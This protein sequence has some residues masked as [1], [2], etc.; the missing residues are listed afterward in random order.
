[1]FI[2]VRH[3]RRKRR[4]YRL[5]L[6]IRCNKKEEEM[7]NWKKKGKKRHFYFFLSFFF[8]L[9]FHLSFR[10]FVN[11]LVWISTSIH[12]CTAR[13]IQ[14]QK[15]ILDWYKIMNTDR[16]TKTQCRWMMK[17]VIVSTPVIVLSSGKCVLFS[18]F[19]VQ[20]KLLSSALSTSLQ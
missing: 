7:F 11:V 6:S 12:S 9:L 18:W 1:V 2:S 19:F 10:E 3:K 16:T 13:S 17:S 14:K 8:F 5:F 4:Y 15:I 20:E